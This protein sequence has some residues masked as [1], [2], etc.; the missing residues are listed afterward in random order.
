MKRLPPG[1]RLR[2]DFPRFGLLQYAKRF[3]AAPHSTALTLGGD[4][5]EAVTLVAPLRETARVSQSSDFHCVTTWS[6]QNLPWEGVRFSDFYREHVVPRLKKGMQVR[7]VQLRGQDGYR[8]QL[9]L[10][11]L[12]D[13]EVLIAD[14]LHGLPLG[15]DHGAPLR[16]VAPAHY[17]YKQVKHL[18]G[19]E[20]WQ[21]APALKRGHLAFM[22]HPRGR[23]ACEERG[24]WIPGMVLRY[25]YRPLIAMAAKR[26]A[27]AL[28][29]YQ[30][31]ATD[32][33]A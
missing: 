6:H 18:A 21:D 25:L 29:K 23:V 2:T 19:I 32:W 10:C 20:F 9:P 12:L 7:I 4:T 31:G 3:P 27:A 16:L 14:R 26:F 33:I 22:D 8:T 5:L 24:R 11:D 13:D 1:Q 15:I 17:G 28:S 30:A